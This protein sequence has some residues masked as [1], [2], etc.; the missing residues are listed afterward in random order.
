[1]R[2]IGVAI[3]IVIMEGEKAEVFEVGSAA[4]AAQHQTVLANYDFRPNRRLVFV[5]SSKQARHIIPLA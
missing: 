5:G 4:E 3:R 1:M 2:V